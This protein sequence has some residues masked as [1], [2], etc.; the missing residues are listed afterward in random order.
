[1]N[2][3]K[4]IVLFL[5]AGELEHVGGCEHVGV[6]QNILLVLGPG[7]I[8]EFVHVRSSALYA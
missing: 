2:L 8:V 6:L 4:I 1:M 3:L 5:H 7:L